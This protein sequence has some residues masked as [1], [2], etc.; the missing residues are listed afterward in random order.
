M[1]FSLG[2]LC[3]YRLC[4][5]VDCVSIMLAT[6]RGIKREKV[7]K[8]RVLEKQKLDGGEK[9]ERERERKEEPQSTERPIDSAIL[10]LVLWALEYTGLLESR[11]VIRWSAR[12]R[13]F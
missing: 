7:E 8:S 11:H 1:N 12:R 9:G 6:E 10:S 4:F 13:S 5:K 2:G 3:N